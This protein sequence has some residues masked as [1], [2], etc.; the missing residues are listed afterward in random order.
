MQPIQVI[1]IN[2]GMVNAYILKQDGAVLID[3]GIP[4]S[5]S[6]TLKALQ[7]AGIGLQ[8]LRLIL[9]THGHGDHAGSAGHLQVMT[10]APIAVHKN[11][12][13]M[14]ETGTQGCLVPTMLTGRISDIFLRSVNHPRY[15]AVNP[16]IVISGT[17][18]LAP[19]GIE[20]TVVPTPGHTMGSVSVV[21]GNGDALTGDLIVPQIPSGKP[22]L[23]FWADNPLDI[24]KSINTLLSFN[25][26][27]FLPGHGSPFSAEEVRQ[28]VD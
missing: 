2:L 28:M 7:Q 18:D 12:A 14:L 9:V 17:M 8:E 19:Y 21:L 26:Q 11:D 4:G 13:G 3:T 16:P 27:T 5:E 1:S 25:P 23:P 15:P 6:A 20:G 24:Y 10:G 22:G